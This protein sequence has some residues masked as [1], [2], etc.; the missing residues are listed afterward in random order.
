MQSKNKDW[1][2]FDTY[3]RQWYRVILRSGGDFIYEVSILL[4]PLN[5]G[6]G[7][8]FNIKDVLIQKRNMNYCSGNIKSV[9][10]HELPQEVYEQL[11]KRFS[12]DR[13]NTL[14]HADL[15]PLIDWR[16]YDEVA[17]K[18]VPLEDCIRQFD[19]T[20]QDVTILKEGSG[21]QFLSSPQ[22]KERF[23][24]DIR[25]GYQLLGGYHEGRDKTDVLVY[26]TYDMTSG[27]V[28]LDARTSSENHDSIVRF[29]CHRVKS[30]QEEFYS[31]IKK[32]TALGNINE[33][34]VHDLH[35]MI[36]RSAVYIS[37]INQ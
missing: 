33:E 20:Y 14:L 11:E 15:Y 36:D 9:W 23:Q 17:E 18:Q 16:R 27:K 8:W 4:T 5:G 1:F 2:K 21:E 31:G 28:I 32:L 26:L 6:D 29:Q 34:C 37:Q 13:L 25:E 3:W 7:E 30:W 12:K 35:L 22:F 24:L 19:A 10:T